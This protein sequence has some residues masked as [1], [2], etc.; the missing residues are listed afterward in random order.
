MFV[1]PGPLRPPVVTIALL[2]VI[3]IAF[4]LEVLWGGPDSVP[5]LGRMGALARSN[6]LAGE[7]WRCMS[8][9]VLHGSLIHVGLNSYVLWRLGAL[10]ERLIGSE[11]FLVLYVVSA[12]MAALGSAFLLNGLSVGASGAIWGLL[13][14]QAAIAFGA[15]GFVPVEARP[16]LRRVAGSNLMINAAIS[17]LPHVDWAAH[18]SG[19]AAGLVLVGSGFLLRGLPGLAVPEPPSPARRTIRLLAVGLGALYLLGAVL[20]LVSGRAWELARPPRFALVELPELG[21]RMRLPTVASQGTFEAGAGGA[22]MT[23]GHEAGPVRIVVHR[24]PLLDGPTPAELEGLLQ[25]LG[26]PEGLETV[27]APHTLARGDRSVSEA[28]YRFPWRALY[29]LAL[30]N[31]RRFAWSVEV[32]IWPDQD[33]GYEDTLEELLGSFDESEG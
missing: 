29:D 21:A 26:D 6:L 28:R 14:A 24:M 20:G 27:R 13:G 1:V 12:L 33:R 8:S 30:W 16:A 31:G 9:G 15:G 23:F 17:F 3:A 4:A 22:S 7:W 32:L 10:T 19:G 25:E 2:V 18:F 5:V 11:R